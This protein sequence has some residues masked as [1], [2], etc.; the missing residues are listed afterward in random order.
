MVTATLSVLTDVTQS[1]GDGVLLYLDRRI[2]GGSISSMAVVRELAFPED[3]QVLSA[4]G[5]VHL[6][7]GDSIAVASYLDSGSPNPAYGIQ[8]GEWE[9]VF[10]AFL[11]GAGAAGFTEPAAPT[12]S[13]AD[14]NNKALVG[15]AELTEQITN[16]LK[17][18]YSPS[19]FACRAV[20]DFAAGSN[21][22]ILIPWATA[23]ME[24][25]GGWTYNGN[26]TEFRAPTVGVYLISAFS[27][28]TRDG[29]L[30][31]YGAYQ[32]NLLRNGSMVAVHQR[33]NT[34]IGYGTTISTSEI[35]F[36]N[37]GDTVSTEF[38]GTGTGL[39]W[40]NAPESPNETWHSFSGVMLAPAAQ[41]MKA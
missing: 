35:M 5:I 26:G 6:R 28:F 34:R 38:M 29:T 40:K 31:P 30:G 9:G 27:C 25:S 18:L 23:V 10:S 8:T 21:Q 14:W 17:T 12:G 24:S 1:A 20:V 32:L 16:P 4:I 2:S 37:A 3:V 22:R 11:V 7:S 13:L 39:A 19:R 15:P 36:L 33:Q 41:S